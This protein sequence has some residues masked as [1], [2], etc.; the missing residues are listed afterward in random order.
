MVTTIFRTQFYYLQKSKDQKV[1]CW[2]VLGE[3][4]EDRERRREG[5]GAEGGRKVRDQCLGFL[6]NSVWTSL[7]VF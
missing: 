1:V 4:Q 7:S 6:I 3:G 2:E 5:E